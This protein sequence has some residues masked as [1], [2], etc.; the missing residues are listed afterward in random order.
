MRNEQTVWLAAHYHF[1]ATYSCRIPL[2]SMSS[3][4]ASPG[5]GPATVRLA[6]IKVGCEL[7][8][9]EYV[10]QVLFPVLRAALLRVRPPARVAVSQQVQRIYKGRESGRQSVQ[11]VESLGYREVAQ[12]QGLLTVYLQAPVET[13]NDFREVF[14]TIGYWGQTDSFTTCME[15]EEAAPMENE[16]ALPLRALPLRTSL[17]AFFSCVMTE[18]RH[19]SLAWEEVVSGE[20]AV[21]GDPFWREL[22]VWPMLLVERRAA[23]KLLIRHPFTGGVSSER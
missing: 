21:E 7:F 23:N 13:T 19:T 15:V 4:Q 6:M 12:A 17:G 8:G 11:L 9:R 14:K 20:R 18:F 3:A 22:Y 16:C 5:P 10:R 2:S 1:P